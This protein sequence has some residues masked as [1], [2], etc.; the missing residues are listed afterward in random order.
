MTIALVDAL[1]GFEM[2]IEHLDG[3]KVTLSLFT[4]QDGAFNINLLILAVWGCVSQMNTVCVQL[5]T[6]LPLAQ[7]LGSPTGAFKVTG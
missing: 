5:A 3:H 4:T 2:D 1:N 7:C 6:C